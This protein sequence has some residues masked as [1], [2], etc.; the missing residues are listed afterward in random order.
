MAER[1]TKPAS[2]PS[3]PPDAGPAGAVAEPAG[4]GRRFVAL[5]IDWILC[6]LVSRLFVG[7]VSEGWAPLVVLV[8]EYT[9][10][11]GLFAQT[12][13]M[14]L[15]RV[16]CESVATGGAPGIPRTLLR[17]VLLALFIP[18]LIMDGQRRGLHDRVA[19]TIVT[20]PPAPQG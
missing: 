16:R 14:K 15:A 6:L 13:G 2:Y 17:S 7:S 3:G 12:P 11:V 10:F 20:G 4:L 5:M 18:A 9:L 19:G 1:T 8:V